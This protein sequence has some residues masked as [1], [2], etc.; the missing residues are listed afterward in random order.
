MPLWPRPKPEQLVRR[1]LTQP[2]ALAAAAEG[3]L[4]DD[5]QRLLQSSRGKGWS[6][7]DLPLLDEARALLDGPAA[8][9]GHLIVDEAQDLT[10]MQLRMLA[11]PVGGRD[12]DPRRHRPG[13]RADLVP[14]LVGRCSGAW[15]RTWRLRSRS[16]GSPTACRAR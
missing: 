7:A 12:H 6:D 9:H 10:P 2:E 16:S 13:V 3:I 8:P 15:H 4:D 5:D 14:S 11:A 1:L